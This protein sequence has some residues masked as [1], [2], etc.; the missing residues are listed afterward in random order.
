[1]WGNE[2]RSIYGGALTQ[3]NWEWNL[4]L[5]AID[6]SVNV[7]IPVSCFFTRK[8]S[9]SRIIQ[10]SV[11]V[12][13]TPRVIVMQIKQPFNW[14]VLH[15]SLASFKQWPCL[16]HVVEQ[17]FPNVHISGSRNALITT[18]SFYLTNSKVLCNRCIRRKEPRTKLRT[19]RKPV[20]I[21]AHWL[22]G[23]AIQY[24]YQLFRITIIYTTTWDISAIWLA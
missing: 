11:T 18:H 24:F 6:M 12:Q 9:I 21:S 4:F 17:I 23:F 16:I 15:V 8:L 1:M 5:C 3:R 7:P 13:Y 22:I 20:K 19:R 2:V 14:S 10:I